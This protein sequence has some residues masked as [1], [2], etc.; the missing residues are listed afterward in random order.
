[1]DQKIE[2]SHFHHNISTSLRNIE[3]P[4]N[5]IR[6]LIWHPYS[7]NVF[8]KFKWKHTQTHPFQQKRIIVVHKCQRNHVPYTQKEIQSNF[9]LFGNRLKRESPIKCF[10]L[11]Q[12]H[13]C[14]EQ[15]VIDL[16][17][18]DIVVHVLA[19]GVSS[20]SLMD[21][22]LALQVNCLFCLCK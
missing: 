5:R 20:R 10:C 1:M 2:I 3:N 19:D 11:F 17:N 16:L 15:T 9:L 4:L 18:E 7:E 6:R 13:V 12:A 21:R 22:G 8:F 14:I